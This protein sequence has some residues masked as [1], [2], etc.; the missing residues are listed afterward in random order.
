MPV[1]AKTW[2]P[3]SHKQVSL[4]SALRLKKPIAMLRSG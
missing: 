2:I 4:D 3:R 1:P